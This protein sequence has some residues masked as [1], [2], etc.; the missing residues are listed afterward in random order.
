MSRDL[1]LLAQQKLF[2]G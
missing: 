2:F 1:V